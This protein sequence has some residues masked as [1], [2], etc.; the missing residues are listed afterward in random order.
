MSGF[1]NFKE[2]I[3]FGDL[4]LGEQTILKWNSGNWRVKLSTV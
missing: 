4:G 2:I 3:D 1:E